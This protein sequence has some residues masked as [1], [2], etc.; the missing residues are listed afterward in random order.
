MTSAIARGLGIRVFLELIEV[1]AIAVHVQAAPNSPVVAAIQIPP[2]AE[3]TKL[4]PRTLVHVF[5]RDVPEGTLHVHMRGSVAPGQHSTLPETQ[6]LLEE[7]SLA[8]YKLMFVGEIMGFQW[9]KNPMTRSLVLQCADPSNYWDYAYQWKNTDLFG[10]GFKALFSGGGTNLFNDFLYEPSEI[11]TGVIKQGMR[12]GSVQYPN[13]RGL[14]GGIMRMIEQIGGSYLT[15]DL[16]EFKGANPFFALAEMR[17]HITQMIAAYDKDPTSDRLLGG[18]WTGM[19]G[20]TLGN[21]GD[22]VSIRT[23]IVALMNAVFHET[24]GQPCPMYRPGTGSISGRDSAKLSEFPKYAPALAAAVSVRETLSDLSAHLA[25]VLLSYPKSV[26]TI[27]TSAAGACRTEAN[28]WTHKDEQ[29][30]REAFSGSASALLSCRS[31]ASNARMA[32][33]KRVSSIQAKIDEVQ[34]RLASIPRLS[35]TWAKEK[36]PA[37]LYQQIFRP[38]VWFSAPPRCNV[39]FPDEL[40]EFRYDRMFMQEPTRLLLKTSTEFGEDE[41]FDSFYVAPRMD[42]IRQGKRGEFNAM[43]KNDLLEHEVFTGILPA[44]EKMG[45]FTIFAAKAGKINGAGTKIGLVQRST[46]FLYFNKRFESRRASVTCAFKPYLAMGF[47][48]LVID[49][50]MDHAVL[51]K[52]QELMASAGG[53]PD[54]IAARF[55]MHVLGTVSQL[56]HSLDQS[57]QQVSRMTLTYARQSDESVE[58]LGIDKDQRVIKRYPSDALRTTDV[59][60]INPPSVGSIGPG[61]GEIVTVVD[62]TGQ[63]TAGWFLPLYNGRLAGKKGGMPHVPVGVQGTAGS[64]DKKVGELFGRSRVLTFRAYR[65]QERI[66][67][68]RQE[69]IDLPIE[70]YIR[71]GWYG[72]CWHPGQ[73]GDVYQEFFGIGAITDATQVGDPAG[74]PTGSADEEPLDPLSTGDTGDPVNP[75]DAMTPGDKAPA[76]FTLPRKTSA[77]LGGKDVSY[78]SVKDAV[79][80]LMG[81]YSYVTQNHMGVDEFIKA[82]SWRP[83]ASMLDMFGSPDLQY[84]TNGDVVSGQ[85]GFHSRAAGDFENIFTLLP[86]EVSVA[87]GVQKYGKDSPFITKGDTRRRKRMAVLQYLTALKQ[88]PGILG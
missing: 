79:E 19:F 51:A 7:S 81:V 18:D 77:Q 16:K 62:V 68:Y 45:E 63:Y 6:A 23:S 76:I 61:Y 24:D 69:I 53:I 87:I 82:Y 64:F 49:R 47:P 2:L 58:F 17:L 72:D 37:R 56:E 10:P 54:E 15:N 34:S 43:L 8:N 66:P 25:D 5:F 27:L 73:I 35:I 38:D 85:E 36:R 12:S 39:I 44:F 59:A 52:Y 67:R 57:G 40:T 65:V 75:Q 74:A 29:A 41:M 3:G 14:M 60:A 80:F 28:K 20:R 31:V 83:I 42:L 78:T 32:T 33:D 50:K 4:F 26:T 1:P 21:L 48:A 71:P 22:Q 13:I 88:S 86:P 11:L 46:N 84:D 55:G 30:L 9:S 70:E